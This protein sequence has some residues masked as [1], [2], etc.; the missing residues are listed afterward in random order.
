MSQL[1]VFIMKKN[2]FTAINES[3]NNLVD[4]WQIHQIL[5][6]LKVL[7]SCTYL[8]KYY[9][10]IPI[11]SAITQIFNKSLM[12]KVLFALFA[13]DLKKLFYGLI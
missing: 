9:A 6:I 10:F 3:L 12:Q 1:F 11:S 7:N 4:K 8:L 13:K 2:I 5:Q